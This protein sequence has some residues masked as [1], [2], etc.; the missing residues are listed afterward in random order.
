MICSAGHRVKEAKTEPRDPATAFSTGLD[1]GR[2][3]CI[4]VRTLIRLKWNAK[5][6]HLLNFW[7]FNF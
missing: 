1:V 6:P 5:N 3:K 2:V 7:P 4:R